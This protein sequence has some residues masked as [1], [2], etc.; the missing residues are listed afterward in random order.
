MR[1]WLMRTILLIVHINI[2]ERK[3]KRASDD[4]HPLGKISG[5]IVQKSSNRGAARLGILLGS[6]GF[7]I[8]VLTS[9]L[10]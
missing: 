4:H 9:V 7:T 8:I 2:L 3:R 10:G 1:D 6:K 5:T